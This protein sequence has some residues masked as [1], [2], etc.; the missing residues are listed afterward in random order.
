[1][2]GERKK[3]MKGGWR[4]IDCNQEKYAAWDIDS[5]DFCRLVAFSMED[6][7]GFWELEI[8]D[9]GLSPE[10]GREEGKDMNLS[11]EEREEVGMKLR[12][13]GLEFVT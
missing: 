6:G 4:S 8:G 5:S 3:M 7:W 1:M 2:G 12:T 9:V 10:D 13:A 11:I